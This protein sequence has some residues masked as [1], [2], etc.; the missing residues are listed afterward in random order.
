MLIQLRS[1]RTWDSGCT[2]RPE[3]PASS[4]LRPSPGPG[5]TNL[6]SC[7][8]PARTAHRVS[9]VQSRAP[10]RGH[11]SLLR[12]PS[13]VRPGTC[14]TPGPAD[15]ARRTG[16]QNLGSKLASQQAASH[17]HP[18]TAREDLGQHCQTGAAS[19]QSVHGSGPAPAQGRQT[20]SLARA[21][22]GQPTGYPQFS[23]GPRPRDTPYSPGHSPAS[24][25][26]TCGTLGPADRARRSGRRNLRSKFKRSYGRPRVKVGQSRARGLPSGQGTRGRP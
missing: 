12:P 17:A 22:R 23:P 6:E 18:A 26:G 25:P 7:T 24:A 3:Q 20:S 14:G 11:P 4:Q 21:R 2:A 15:Q 1:G 5:P 16:W 13:R 19:P 10:A 9:T 8:G